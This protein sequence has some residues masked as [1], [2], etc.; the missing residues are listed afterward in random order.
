MHNYVTL[1]GKNL[2]TGLRESHDIL[3]TDL[4]HVVDRRE[5]TYLTLKSTRM[6]IIRNDTYQAT[7]MAMGQ[8]DFAYF[9]DE[10]NL[11]FALYITSA[12]VQALKTLL[13]YARQHQLMSK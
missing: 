10:T 9:L 6:G 7:K 8:R 3:L 13:A 5:I 4:V 2:R 12:N 11:T 1:S